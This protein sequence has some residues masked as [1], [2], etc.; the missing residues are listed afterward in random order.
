MADKNTTEVQS[1]DIYA[2]V[3]WKKLRE[4]KLALM[5]V[6]DLGMQREHME[7]LLHTIDHFQDVA[8]ASGRFTSKEVFNDTREVNLFHFT[9]ITVPNALNPRD[10]AILAFNGDYAWDMKCSDFEV[11]WNFND[12]MMIDVADENDNDLREFSPD[13]ISGEDAQHNDAGRTYKVKF[14]TNV[15]VIVTEFEDNEDAIRSAEQA[16]ITGDLISAAGYIVDISL[17]SSVEPSIIG[18]DEDEDED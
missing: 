18:D 14:Y 2:D 5:K 6:I 4:Q 16:E 17:S 10:A 3:D 1:V 12:C 8:V 7:S 9:E 11:S 13:D 15:E